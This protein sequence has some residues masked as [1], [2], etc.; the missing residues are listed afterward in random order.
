MIARERVER[1]LDGERRVRG[2]RGRKPVDDRL[3]HGRA[4]DEHGGRRG[5]AHADHVHVDD[6]TEAGPVGG[7]QSRH[8]LLAAVQSLFFTAE[9]HQADVML[10]FVRRERPGD[11]EYAGGP[12]GVVVRARRRRRIAAGIVRRVQMTA[13]DDELPRRTAA[14][15]LRDDVHA[16]ASRQ[17][18]R[19]AADRIAHRGQPGLGKSRG[20]GVARR[21]RMAREE[22]REKRDVGLVAR[23]VQRGDNRPHPGLGARGHVAGD[24][25]KDDRIR[26]ERPD[27]IV[28]TVAAEAGGPRRGE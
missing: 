5:V 27:P 6:G 4:F 28:V 7:A 23:R 22:G 8:E 24:L 21:Q 1:G 12:A 11:C 25:A 16:R 2:G 17:G 20:V 3:R 9:Q 15:L 10:G 14:R 19:R 18:D 13:D 26:L